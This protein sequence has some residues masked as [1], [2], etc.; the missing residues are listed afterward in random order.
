MTTLTDIPFDLEPA[1]LMKRLHVQPDT[2]DAAALQRLIRRAQAIGRPK[3]AYREAFVEQR[4][5]ETV[6]VG[7]VTFTSAMLSRNLASAHRL[8]AYVATC[9]L[10][11][12]EAAPDD[13][14]PLVTFWWDAIKAD[15]LG[16]ACL[17]LKKHLD[18][19]YRLGKTAT[20]SPGAG[21]VTVWPIEQQR[22]LFALMGDV[23]AEIGVELTPS[24]LMVPNKTVSGVRFATEADFRTC[25]VCRRDPC[26]GRGAPFDGALWREIG[27]E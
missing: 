26:P 16:A 20:M 11:V 27:H 19:T 22:E 3:A 21:D 17:Y 4:G 23:R 7:G 18:M 6:S 2:E 15:L 5:H 9:G 12:H 1:S 14:D 25:Q 24:C 10:E 8:F 13:R